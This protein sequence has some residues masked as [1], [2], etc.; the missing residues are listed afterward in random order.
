LK[1]LILHAG[2]ETLHFSGLTRFP[3]IARRGLGVI[4]T[5]HHVGP[6]SDDVFD[7][8]RGLTVTPEFLD[9][10]LS[11]IRASGYELVS[12]AEVH[13]RLTKGG[14]DGRFAAITLDDGYRNNRENALPVFERHD[15]PFTV[16]VTTG[17]SEGKKILWW[18]IMARLIN[19]QASI[20]FDFGQGSETFPTET[21]GEKVVFWGRLRDWV[22]STHPAVVQTRVADY[23]H[24]VGFDA[25]GLTRELVMSKDEIVALARHP[26]ASIGAHTLT[27]AN[28]RQMTPDEALHEMTE[29]AD[30]LAGWLGERPRHFAYPYG[31][32]AAAAAQQFELARQAGF[33]LAVTTRPGVLVPEHVRH[34][35]ALP[36][37]SI[38]GH[39]Q[40]ARHLDVLMSGAP[41]ALKNRFRT[42][43]VA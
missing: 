29:S 33:D 12:L 37:I 42:L 26:L 10:A 43:D 28:L 7:P 11:Y 32:R 18:E 24:S 23:A 5:L 39:F 25:L 14:K 16:F 6:M 13:R 9:A 35:T 21:P 41:F 36:R 30:I 2:M 27:H 34:L 3:P 40:K 4:L 1:N 22:T 38:N 15:A 31:F 19:R 20:T 17:F 8:N